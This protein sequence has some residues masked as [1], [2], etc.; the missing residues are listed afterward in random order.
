MTKDELKASLNNPHYSQIII[1][2]VVG[3]LSSEE[4]REAMTKFVD[5]AIVAGIR[6]KRNRN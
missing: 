6:E 1:N 4:I 5:D 3:G 2:A